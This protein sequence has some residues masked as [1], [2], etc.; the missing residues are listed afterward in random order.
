MTIASMTG[1]ARLTG[2]SSLGPFAWEIKAVNAKGLDVRL[3]IASLFDSIEAESR[4]R[5]ARRVTRGTINVTLTAQRGSAIPEVR[6]N[7]DLL[8]KL[9]SA[10]ATVDLHG[11]IAPATLDGLLSVR[12]VVEVI[13]AE[14]TEEQRRTACV[15]VLSSLDDALDQLVAMRAREGRALGA[16]LSTK[17]SR[18]QNLVAAA[19]AC[20]ARRPDVIAA[21]LSHTIALLARQ[22][23]FDQNRLYQEALLLAAKAD[24]REELDRLVTHAAAA[25]ELLAEGGAIGRKLDFLA[26]EFGREA[27]TLC[28]KSND[29]SLTNIGLEL[30]AE[31]EQFRE[32]IQNIE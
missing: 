11:S 24:V 17:L 6:I 4:A 26:Q 28:A 31:I 21:R 20:P 5:I 29:A 1:F 2:A 14:D 3:R 22:A 7:Q 23:N 8:Q 19:D 12:G 32:Q 18:I 30:R 10:I 25:L 13:D 15:H 9:A 27:A 16:I